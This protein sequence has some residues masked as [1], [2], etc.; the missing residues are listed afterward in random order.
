MSSIKRSI[1]NDDDMMYLNYLRA[2]RKKWCLSQDE[3]AMLLSGVSAATLS[4]YELG[5]Q[6]P[7]AEILLGCEVIFG[8]PLRELFP[9]LYQDRVDSVMRRA[10][11]LDRELGDQQDPP[12]I[13]K[14]AL[15]REMAERAGNISPGI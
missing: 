13:I 2:H 4:R 11:A 5:Q 6:T 9:G 7:R 12:S 3:L 1:R 8:V 10:A 15:L 14:R